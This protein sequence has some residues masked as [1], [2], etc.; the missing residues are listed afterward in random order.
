MCIIRIFTIYNYTYWLEP[1]ECGPP[2]KSEIGTYSSLTWL[3]VHSFPTSSLTCIDTCDPK[4]PR[5]HVCHL[6]TG[7]DCKEAP[8]ECPTRLGSFTMPSGKTFSGINLLSDW[9]MYM[10]YYLQHQMYF[11]DAISS[12]TKTPDLSC[13]SRGAPPDVYHLVM[14]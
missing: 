3:C 8:R 1:H 6:L 9:G 4:R 5:A 2:E 14:S 7:I 11:Q 10:E 12:G 13:A